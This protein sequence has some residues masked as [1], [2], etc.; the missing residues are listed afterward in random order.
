MALS[1]MRRGVDLVDLVDLVELG[2]FIKNAIQ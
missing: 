1:A 2:D